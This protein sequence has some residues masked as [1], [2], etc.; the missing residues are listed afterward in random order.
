MVW[1][2]PAPQYTYDNSSIHGESLCNGTDMLMT[3]ATTMRDATG[4][5]LDVCHQALEFAVI[6]QNVAAGCNQMVNGF[7]GEHERRW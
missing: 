3:R 4:L 1:I 7:I 5:L 2:D 6:S